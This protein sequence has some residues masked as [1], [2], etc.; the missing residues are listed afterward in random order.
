M[1]CSSFATG[2]VLRM[3]G[4]LPVMAQSPS[5][6]T[7]R[8][9]ARAVRRCAR[10]ACDETAPSISGTSTPSGNCC[11]A[12]SGGD[13]RPARGAALFREGAGGAGLHALAAAGAR[14]GLAPGLIEFADQ[15]RVD[16]A[17]HDVPDVDALHFGAHADTT[18]TE[19]AAV[20]IEH[21]ALL[22]EVH[23]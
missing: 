5:A 6:T 16:A 23:L 7:K 17:T 10:S 8:L 19:N 21:V 1:R 9:R 11:A 3:A 4:T 18:G 15:T 12:T 22:R 20:V 13:T 2:M 14:A